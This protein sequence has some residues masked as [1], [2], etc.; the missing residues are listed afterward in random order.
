MNDNIQL[1]EEKR[2]QKPGGKILEQVLD[3]PNL[4][5]EQITFAAVV[6]YPIALIDI[7]TTEQSVENFEYVQWII[8]RLVALKYDWQEI[9]DLLGLNIRY[10]C[11]VKKLFFGDGLIDENG[12]V[13][14]TGE[15][16]LEENGACKIC[17]KKGKVN[18]QMDVLN[19][20]ILEK[21]W[22]I[23][24]QYLF[25]KGDLKKAGCIIVGPDGMYQHDIEEL[26]RKLMEH[27]YERYLRYSRKNILSSN[28][29]AIDNMTCMHLRYIRACLL[30]FEGTDEYVVFVP[31]SVKFSN[32]QNNG[33][34]PITVPTERLCNIF[35]LPTSRIKK[36]CIEYLKATVDLSRK[37]LAQITSKKAGSITELMEKS[38]KDR[39]NIHGPIDVS[40]TEEWNVNIYLSCSSLSYLLDSDQLAEKQKYFAM[41][42]LLKLLLEVFEKQKAY[43]VDEYYSGI[44][45]TVKISDAKMQDVVKNMVDDLKKM[46]SNVKKAVPEIAQRI[47]DLAEKNGQSKTV[48]DILNEIH[49]GLENEPYAA[50]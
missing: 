39:Y 20:D 2:W 40:K 16:T 22:L 7:E 38:F 23:E 17:L 12:A 21:E 5:H 27:G 30:K 19:L 41:L 32:H 37:Y 8:L 45:M 34:S 47:I 43:V 4:S 25:S 44:V 14:Q 15:K 28:I 48:L 6:Y 49:I 3:N 11:S 50:E 33:W 26:N 9:A 24:S 42:N 18:V 46:D 36:D 29:K 35:S 10:I 1:V 13:T 31:R